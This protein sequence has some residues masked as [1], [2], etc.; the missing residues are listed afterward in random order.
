[1]ADVGQV[2]INSAKIV[3]VGHTSKPGDIGRFTQGKHNDT[4]ENPLCV[5][6][7]TGAALVLHHTGMPTLGALGNH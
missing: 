6:Q 5:E 4:Q 2:I 1:M 3:G 7:V